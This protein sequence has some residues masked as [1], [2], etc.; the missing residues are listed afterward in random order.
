MPSLFTLFTKETPQ[1]LR[2]LVRLYF[3][4]M[5]KIVSYNSY[6]Y[7][8]S[9]VIFNLHWKKSHC[10]RKRRCVLSYCLVF[11]RITGRLNNCCDRSA[12]FE[13]WNYSRN[14]TGCRKLIKYIL[15]ESWEALQ[16][17]SQGARSRHQLSFIAI[18]LIFSMLVKSYI[19][20]IYPLFH[21][22]I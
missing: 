13:K 2:H 12:I 10:L 6:Y 1:K 3:V 5:R 16:E 17:G 11:G 18:L 8:A 19:K 9:R 20:I 22:T 21:I 15:G 4:R 7:Y 14:V